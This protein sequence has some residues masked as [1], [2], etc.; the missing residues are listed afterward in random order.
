MR[1]SGQPGRRARWSTTTRWTNISYGSARNCARWR[2]S[3]ASPRCAASV[4]DS[5]ET[6]HMKPSTLRGRLALL[7]L[8]TTGI[9][10]L[11]LTGLFNLMLQGRLRA[12]ANDVL[13]T[14]ASV[15]AA[16]VSAHADGSLTIDEPHDDRA[17]DTGTWI[18]QGLRVL[19]RPS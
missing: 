8:F 7:A 3:A 11:V 18:F 9:W 14:R 17:L 4:T 1:C 12:E 10:V 5:H 19:E 15:V 13:K 6:E 16:T 2:A